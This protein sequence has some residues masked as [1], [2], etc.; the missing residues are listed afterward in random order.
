MDDDDDDYKE[1]SEGDDALAGLMQRI[2]GISTA[3]PAELSR[4]F[5]SILGISSEQATFFLSAAN[6]NLEAAVN[7]Y[8]DYSRV[9]APVAQPAVHRALS[10]FYLEAQ[11]TG[12]VGDFVLDSD[13]AVLGS[14]EDEEWEDGDTGLPSLQHVGAGGADLTA[15]NPFSVATAPPAWG[16]IGSLAPAPAPTAPGAPAGL[17]VFGVG[18]TG[19]PPTASAPQQ[20]QHMFMPGG[21]GS[22]GGG[23]DD[24]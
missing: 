17:A 19:Q 10:D 23:M 5:A 11:R 9:A 4:E 7:L 15:P 21:S 2:A 12:V 3:D 13:G 14:F 6:G 1:E 22:A 20:Q 18:Y 8:L 24:V 16:G